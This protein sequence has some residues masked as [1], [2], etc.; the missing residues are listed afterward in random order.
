MPYAKALFVFDST[1]R[2]AVRSDWS[3]PGRRFLPSQREHFTDHTHSRSQAR[4]S[5]LRPVQCK[6][7]T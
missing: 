4:Q 6:I 5:T 1:G 7:D 3:G 2:P